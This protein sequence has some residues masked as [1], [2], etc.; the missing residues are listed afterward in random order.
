[1]ENLPYIIQTDAVDPPPRGTRRWEPYLRE[2]RRRGGGSRR[3]TL[4]FGPSKRRRPN[5]GDPLAF[6]LSVYQ[7]S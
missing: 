6:L 1:M 7:T 2:G 4:P 5:G 3:R